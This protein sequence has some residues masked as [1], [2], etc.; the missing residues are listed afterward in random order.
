MNVEYK[1]VS[2]LKKIVTGKVIIRKRNQ[3]D[4]C[5]DYAID[6]DKELTLF[7]EAINTLKEQIVRLQK[8]LNYKDKSF[9]IQQDILSIQNYI[10]DDE[11]LI[12]G[13]RNEIQTNRRKVKF[14]V[15]KITDEII[16]EITAN[17]DE[18]ISSKASDVEGI[19]ERLVNILEQSSKGLILSG[20]ECVLFVDEITPMDFFSM[21]RSK[22]VGVVA[23]KG[24]I[25]AH[26]AI[27]LKAI[28]VPLLIGVDF[29]ETFE[30]GYAFLDGYS[31]KIVISDNKAMIDSLIGVKHN[32]LSLNMDAR[33]FDHDELKVKV[34]ANISFMN[35]LAEAAATPISGIGLFRTEYL[36]FGQSNFPNEEKQFEAYCTLVKAI[37][38]KEVVVRTFDFGA[39]KIPDMIRMG[40]ESNP[41]LG[42]RG[43][44]YCLRN[45][46]MFKEQIRA[47]LRA[48]VYGNISIMYPMITSVDEM[49]QIKEIFKSAEKELDDEGILYKKIAQGIMIETPAA[50]WISDELA[51]RVDFFC[52]GTNDLTQY[53]LATDRQNPLLEKTYDVC[54][55][56]VKKSIKMVVENAHRNGILVS[57]CGELDS[58]LKLLKDI[59]QMGVD[60]VSVSLSDVEKVKEYICQNT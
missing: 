13:V 10:L 41:A 49:E 1:G 18:R 42:N 17:K 11:R 31:G 24:S 4:R 56:S 9:D 58:D 51:N 32:P 21:D 40:T 29:D 7:D 39:D 45:P 14:A 26:I 35:E 33:V 50:V 37:P 30:G 44:R 15:I 20:E 34:F 3:F 23:R 38:N 59:I 6:V 2:I 12:D 8:G 36:A 5:D 55:S 52:I 22:L 54:H 19:K 53:T 47:I 48:S 60:R 28:D 25:Y 46:A 43:I 16:N 27:L 57:V